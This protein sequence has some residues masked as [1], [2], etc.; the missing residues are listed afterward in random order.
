MSSGHKTDLSGYGWS[1]SL[2]DRREAVVAR[3]VG[4]SCKTRPGSWVT[5]R[6]RECHGVTEGMSCVPERRVLPERSRIK[7]SY[8]ETYSSF[9]RAIGSEHKCLGS[10]QSG[11]LLPPRLQ[12]VRVT[13]SKCLQPAFH[14]AGAARKGASGRSPRIESQPSEVRVTDGV[15]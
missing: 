11:S 15:P 10:R 9:R 14:D 8:R 7:Y 13:E 12:T 3:G 2:E 5:V 1:A 4:P 6:E